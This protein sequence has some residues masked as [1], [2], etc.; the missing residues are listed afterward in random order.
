MNKIC[1]KL[2]IVIIIVMNCSGT[3]SN[4]IIS[5]NINIDNRLEKIKEKGILTIASSNDKPFAYIDPK[6]GELTGIEGEILTEIAKR[7]QINKVEM[8]Y[9]PFQNLLTELNTNND[10]DIVSSGMYVTS[11]R[12]KE[13]LFTNVLYK[14]PEAIIVRKASKFNFKEDLKDAVMGVPSGTIFVELAQKWQKEGLVKEV[15]TIQGQSELILQLVTGEID[16]AMLDSVSAKYLLSND[17]NLNIK[18][19]IPY[20]P[21]IPGFIAAAV[22][23]TDTALANAIDNEIDKMKE[24]Q[25]LFFIL[26]K[27]GLDETNFVS[28]KD[29]HISDN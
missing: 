29:G 6:T 27:Y 7:L 11:E 28:I 9:V 21:E 24:D 8:R 22:R 26:K 25:S 2:L 4:A 17:N 23:K 15:Q 10:I 5:N 20:T 12:K 19:L 1:K 3:T 14:E 18:L 16:A 13:A